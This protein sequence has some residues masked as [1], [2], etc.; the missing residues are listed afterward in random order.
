MLVVPIFVYRMP[1]RREEPQ[2]NARE[3]TSLVVEQFRRYQPPTFNGQGEPLEAEMWLRALERIFD[4]IACNDAHRVSC[5]TFQLTGDAD[6]WWE[7]HKRT[8]TAERLAA[9][10]WNDFKQDVMQKYIPNCYRERKENEFLHLRQG[11]MTVDEYD[12]KFN[13]LSRY[14]PQWV[15]TDEKK[16]ARSEG[17]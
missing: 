11:N 5:A 2:Q 17:G 9:F 12:R 8:I 3:D 16:A 10:T 13:Q 14:A 15:D 7:S 4:H 1:P 6:Y